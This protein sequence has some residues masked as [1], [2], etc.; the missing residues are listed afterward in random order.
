MSLLEAIG[1][2]VLAIALWPYEPGLVE[3]FGRS[4]PVMSY[5]FLISGGFV[6]AATPR[7]HVLS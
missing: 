2:P 6:H 3:L 1:E 4:G 5:V 7:D